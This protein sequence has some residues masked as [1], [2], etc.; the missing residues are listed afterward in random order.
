M[1]SVSEI[2]NFLSYIRHPRRS[3]SISIGPQSEADAY[4]ALAFRRK[5][6]RESLSSVEKSAQTSRPRSL[7]SSASL[8]FGLSKSVSLLGIGPYENQAI[9]SQRRG[10]SYGSNLAVSPTQD[11]S[12]DHHSDI[13]DCYGIAR[14]PSQDRRQD[15]KEQREIF[16][17]IV[18]PRVRY[19]VEVVTKLIVYAGKLNHNGIQSAF[20]KA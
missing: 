2:P 11:M 5:R 8:D 20:T 3:R 13:N 16:S 17:C 12:T 7:R 19:D 1:P 10:K 18:R 14:T 6:R 9:P 4:E 15:E